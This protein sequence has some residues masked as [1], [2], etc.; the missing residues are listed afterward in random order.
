MTVVSAVAQLTF[1]MMT[2]PTVIQQNTNN[3]HSYTHSLHQVINYRQKSL[4]TF[5]R[6]ST[7]M[8]NEQFLGICY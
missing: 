7:T 6:H 2:H 4:K 1:T 3:E 8:E 5:L